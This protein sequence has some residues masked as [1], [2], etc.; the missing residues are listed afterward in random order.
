[1]E[2][3]FFKDRIISISEIANHLNS[4]SLQDD[5]VVSQIDF[6]VESQNLFPLFVDALMIIL[7]KKGGGRIGIDLTEYEINENSLI[8]LQPKNYIFLSECR[9][10]TT[11]MMVACSRHVIEDIIPKLSDVLPLLVHHRTA[12]VTHLSKRDSETLS[13][14]FNLI[15]T[16]LS[17]SNGQFIKQEV[18]RLLQ[19][20]LYCMMSIQSETESNPN[21][22]RTRKDE[23][24]AKFILEVSDGFRKE[25]HVNYYADKLCITPKHLS[26]VVKQISGRT[27]GEWIDNFV[28][29]E[30]KVLL[31]TTDRT[32][33]EI[34]DMLN[35]RN[36][37][38]FGKF[39]KHLTGFT[40]T[41]YR[42]ANS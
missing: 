23:I 19:A 13:N 39:F 14:Y 34:S 17:G 8:V 38:F 24:M 7:V 6:D 35:F 26:A 37:S 33:Q 12:P 28:I 31:K 30:A 1:M 32:I 9:P 11:A 16:R 18:L 3:E 36:Q 20:A 22:I 4:Q 40:P 2:Q 41:S 15:K 21:H 25:R 10:D 42:K 5:V 27:A 29:M